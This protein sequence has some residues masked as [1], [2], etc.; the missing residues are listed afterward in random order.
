MIVI[1]NRRSWCV[2]LFAVAALAVACVLVA[3]PLRAQGGGGYFIPGDPKAG[4]RSFFDKGC[5]R[6][7]SALGEGGHSAP[8]LA[9]A[10]TGHLSSAELLAAMW[11]H[12]PEMWEKMR[13]EG[14]APPKFAETDMAN[15]FAFLYSVRSLDEPGDAE[16]GRRLLQEKRCLECHGVGTEGKRQAPD[17]LKWAAYRNPVS[18]IQAMWNHAPAMQ[19][20]MAARGVKW[21]VF[22]GNDA[23]DMIAYIR[24][25][26]PSA[27]KPA[28]LRPADPE[29]G[30][31]IFREKGCAACHAVGH[32]SRTAPDLRSRTLPRTLGQFAADMWNHAPAMRASM[33]ARNIA[34]P[35]FTNKEMADL[36]AYL[37][38]E[39]YFE[40]AGSAERGAR[41]FQ[42]KGCASCHRS[43][44][45]GPDLAGASVSPIHIAT[46]LWNHGPVMF[47]SMQQQQVAWPRF[48]PGEVV[49][50]IEFLG[51]KAAHR[52]DSG[53]RQ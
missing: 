52:R 42:S 30:R 9:R 29:A 1:A 26:A 25:S 13:I 18:W 32:G 6:C 21:P 43:G 39:R 12:A 38:A 47:Q 8:D 49:D 35:Q 17:L 14:V 24:R 45:A 48:Q 2:L 46:S 41:L 36:I 37:F 27:A 53:G 44:G 10:P 19:S 11:N 16:R 51:S 50:L 40:P 31:K 33:Q 7:H 23:P 28:Y 34:R 15:L 20:A 3:V 22:D 5:A 4:M